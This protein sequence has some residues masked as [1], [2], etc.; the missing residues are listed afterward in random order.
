MPWACASEQTWKQFVK[1]F[2]G[3][4]SS[5]KEA[6]DPRREYNGVWGK[7]R[8]ETLHGEGGGVTAGD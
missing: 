2:K 5:S 4:C 8:A 1:R 3:E 6:Q 7:V